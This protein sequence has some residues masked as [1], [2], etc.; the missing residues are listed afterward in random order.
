MYGMLCTEE[1]GEASAFT[2]LGSASGTTAPQADYVP[3]P[4]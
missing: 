4:R 1:Y 3:T 2:Y